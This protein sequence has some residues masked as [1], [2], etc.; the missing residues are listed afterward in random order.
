MISETAKERCRILAFW[1]KY[2]TAATKE[3]FKVS[4]PTLFC[5]QKSLKTQ[6]G[7]LEALNKKS[8]APKSKLLPAG[9]P[10]ALDKTKVISYKSSMVKSS[11][12]LSESSSCSSIYF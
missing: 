12:R 1:E 3:A 2:G 7:K 5:W 8:T 9:R 10:V 4:R 11:P 6:L